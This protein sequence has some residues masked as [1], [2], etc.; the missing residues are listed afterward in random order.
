MTAAAGDLADDS[1]DILT[2]PASTVMGDLCRAAQGYFFF[3]TATPA[4]RAALRASVQ[5]VYDRY[6]ATEPTVST[7]LSAVEIAHACSPDRHFR[8][9][10]EKFRAVGIV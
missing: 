7:H 8:H 5:P 10:E 3:G 9:V 1:L 2:D 6:L 4:E